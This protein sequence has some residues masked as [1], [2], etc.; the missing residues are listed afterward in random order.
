MNYT[1]VL[2]NKIAQKVFSLAIISLICVFQR[3]GNEISSCY[4]F[5]DYS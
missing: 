4:I 5:V 2:N 1:C 3:A